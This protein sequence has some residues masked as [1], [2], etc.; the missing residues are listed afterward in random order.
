MKCI[1][2]IWQYF[3]CPLSLGYIY[4]YN[5]FLGHYRLHLNNFRLHTLTVKLEFSFLLLSLWR[6]QRQCNER[7]GT[8]WLLTL[9]LTTTLLQVHVDWALFNEASFNHSAEQKMFFFWKKIQNITYVVAWLIVANWSENFLCSNL[10][11]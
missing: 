2:T 4:I 10:C 11:G 1:K 5:M 6:L 9:L 8:C 3:A 7:T